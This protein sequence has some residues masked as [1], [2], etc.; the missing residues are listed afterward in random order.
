MKILDGIGLAVVLALAATGIA[1]TRP[2]RIEARVP[3]LHW[4]LD[5]DT[6]ALGFGEAGD[7]TTLDVMRELF[8]PHVS[9]KLPEDASPGELGLDPGQLQKGLA[10]FVRKCMH[11]HGTS[12]GA[13]G[14]TA[15]WVKPRPR[16]FRKGVLKF[17][18]TPSGVAPVRE[19]ILRILHNGVAYTA[20]PNFASDPKEDREAL[21]S[22]VQFLLLR[23]KTESSLAFTLD[24]EGTFEEDMDPDELRTAVLGYAEDAYGEVEEEFAGARGQVVNPPIP[25]PASDSAS[26]E[27]GRALF[28]SARTECSACHGQKGDGYGPN[29]YDAEKKEFKLEDSWGNKAQPADLRLGIYR[30][31]NRP[32]DIYRRIYAGIKGTPMPSFGDSLKPEQIWDLVNFVLNIPYDP[33]MK[34]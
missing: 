3:D 15:N 5:P 33:K 16:N 13:D 12:G 14:P 29:V 10:L 32:I 17:T 9:P 1:L 19:D 8:G 6:V 30:G 22:F 21:A 28:L 24:D 25:R 27:R 7:D 2:A 18:S 34:G 11:C 4:D 26:I 23:G 31:G 20:M